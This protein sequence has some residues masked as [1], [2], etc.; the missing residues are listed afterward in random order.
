[1]SN[2]TDAAPR[3]SS[4]RPR[5][6]D[7][8]LRMRQL[9][10]CAAD[11]FIANGYHQVSLGAIAREAKVAVRTIYVKFG[12]KA[13]LF[14]A[15]LRS[16]R[17]TFFIDMPPMDLDGRSLEEVLYDFARRYLRLVTSER[18]VAMQRM[19]ITE[20]PNNPELSRG[21]MQAGPEPT[22]GLLAAFFALPDVRRQLRPDCSPER[23]ARHLITCLMG[24]YLCRLLSA[25]AT[26]IQ[27]PSEASIRE[28]LALFL[29]GS[30]RPNPQ[31]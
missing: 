4:G 17:E 26:P 16:H 10:E 18:A 14:D 23:L 7:V 3:A 11:L 25:G 8:E 2:A 13:G 6:S 28:A 27:A 19:V 30:G 5:Q 21:F 24:D 20:A 15:M 29:N 31:P 22:L 9:V 12:G 1:M